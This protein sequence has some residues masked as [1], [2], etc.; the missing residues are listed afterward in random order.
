MQ[1]LVWYTQTDLRV[2]GWLGKSPEG[3]LIC[4]DLTHTDTDLV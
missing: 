4:T 2:K 1:N 3:V